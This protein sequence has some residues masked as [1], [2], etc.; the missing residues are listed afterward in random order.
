MRFATA[1]RSDLTLFF[2]RLRSVLPAVLVAVVWLGGWISLP[3]AAFAPEGAAEARAYEPA[4]EVLPAFAHLFHSGERG[5]EAFGPRR[6]HHR[7]G[8]FGVS[9]SAAFAPLITVTK[10][11]QLVVD[12]GDG[13][14]EPGETLRYTIEVANDPGATDAAGVVYTDTFDPNTTLVPGSENASP[15]AFDATATV[16]AG[17]AVTITLTGSDGDGD[18]LTFSIVTS[19]TE[20]T[21]GAITPLTA[22]TAEVT[23]TNV[24]TAATSDAFTF[25]TNDG[26]VD[27]NEDATVSILVD[28]PPEVS[29]MEPADGSTNI[30]TDSTLRVTFTEP[31]TLTGDWFDIV[32][33]SS[34]TYNPTGS[35]GATTV[36]V[37]DADPVFLL[38]PS[39]DFDTGEDCT[40][41]FFAAQVTDDDAVDP[42]DNMPADTTFTFSID[43]PPTVTNTDP[44]D[45]R[46]NVPVDTTVTI[47][48]SE[49]VDVTG[50][51]FE[52]VCTS[53][54]TYNPT[55]SGGATTVA[56]TNSNPQ[57]VLDPSS[58][59]S[60]SESCTVTLDAAS[61]T[62]QDGG[63]PPDL[64]DGNSDGV[65]GDDFVFSF[66]TPDV[67]PEVSVVEPADS[68]TDIAV[69][70]TL[71]V[72]FT[73]PVT[74][75]G[76][77]FEIDCNTATF[78]PTGSGGATV[79]TVTDIDP[80]F[81][82]DPNADFPGGET[83]SVTIF[84]DNVEDD[85]VADPPGTL[86][87]DGDGTS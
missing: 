9:F 59:F 17:G 55:G 49:L 45:G 6:R 5:T 16:T 71:R 26:T 63:D 15:L 51:W 61:I 25:K 2:R 27:S 77:W 4:S 3:A 34:G 7:G 85:D 28:D 81:L 62:D 73:E 43:A 82:L 22:T 37:T 54:G 46:A 11:D 32:C 14:A 40:V 76:D 75:T 79:V 41:T 65:P 39:S 87:G 50:D 23:Y 19:P 58:D 48:F 68:S 33:T 70:S 20:G 56:V 21:L 69:D 31:V 80:V 66:S 74:V 24:N 36:T 78:N 60:L 8:L 84:A 42:P 29:L 44:D 67:P 12:D 57:F 35:S 18:G 86:D 1:S 72:T 30:A 53:S 64:L 10:T 13:I 47:D 52:I 83:C 38:D